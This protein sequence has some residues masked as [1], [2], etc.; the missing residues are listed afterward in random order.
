MGYKLAEGKDLREGWDSKG[1]WKSVEKINAPPFSKGE[2]EKVGHPD[3]LYDIEG[4]PPA[5]AGPSLNS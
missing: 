5:N 2:P 4:R 1:L 3:M